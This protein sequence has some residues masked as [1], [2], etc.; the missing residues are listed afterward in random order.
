MANLVKK[1]L[2]RLLVLSMIGIGLYFA[3]LSTKTSIVPIESSA[4]LA[5]PIQEKEMRG[6]GVSI[7]SYDREGNLIS[8]GKSESF[9]LVGEDQLALKDGLEYQFEKEGRKYYTRADN[10]ENLPNGQRRLSANEGKTILLAIE[11]GISIETP[12]PLIYDENEVISTPAPATFKMGQIEGSC[13]GLKYKAEQF[14]ELNAKARFTATSPE[15]TT[16]IN[17]TSLQLDYQERKGI[18]KQG[19]I[20]NH[21]THAI[22]SNT[23]EAEHF[24][25][26][27][28][29]ESS[30]NLQL[31]E[32]QLTGSPTRITWEEGELVSPELQVCFD[33]TGKVLQ[34]VLTGRDATYSSLTAEGAEITG[35]TGQLTF[36][37]EAGAPKSLQSAMPIAISVVQEGSDPLQL[38]GSLGLQSS[39]ENSRVRSTR[40]FGSPHFRMGTQEGQAGSLRVLHDE[41]EVLLSES[42]Q[43][44]DRTQAME[45]R[46]DEILLTRWND[47]QQEIFANRFV[48]ITYAAGTPDVLKSWGE[49][50][51]LTMPSQKAI[52]TGTPARVEQKEQTVE[53]QRIEITQIGPHLYEMKTDD[54][55]NLTMKTEQGNFNIIARDMSFSQE[56]Q[57]VTFT[58]VQKAQLGQ[59]GTLSCRDLKIFMP[60]TAEGRQIQTIDAVGS[61]LYEGQMRHGDT[62]KAFS[63]RSDALAFERETQTIVFQG[64]QKDVVVNHPDGE[65]KGRKLTYHLNDGSMRVTSATHGVTQTTVKFNDQKKQRRR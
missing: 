40:I 31:Q 33:S 48:E 22:H 63:T 60:M 6:E 65:M 20:R 30:Q 11:N 53:A 41:Q 16:H 7:A 47:D 9:V 17:A 51:A 24:N 56:K 28:K 57:I 3:V 61:V 49:T 59:Q 18:I 64:E 15:G 39:F 37:F 54:E 10:F 58:D 5:H 35:K 14:L 12:G 2:T 19:F 4:N 50:L 34:E 46:G 8:S 26:L 52:L 25:I 55:V 45:I 36:Q 1:W 23:L 62:M 29:G 13:V 38:K 43:L 32:A 27:F 21:P 42:A 44:Q